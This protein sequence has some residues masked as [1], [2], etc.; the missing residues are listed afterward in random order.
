MNS[1][2]QVISVCR[3]L[4]INFPDAKI[5]ADYANK[6]LSKDSQEKFSLGYFPTNKTLSTL[7]SMLGGNKLSD[8]GLAYDKI[9]QDDV[10]S[11]MVRC[12]VLEHHNLIMPYKD[13]YGET[14]A[15]VGRS[16][17]TDAERIPLKIPK[18]K[19]T[20]FD[21]GSHLFGLFEAKHSIIKNNL[22]YI[23]EGQFDCITAHSK[24]L[25]NVIALG[26]SSMTFEQ[27][28]LITRYTNNLILS[29]DNDAAGKLGS[30]RIM[31]YYS[32]YANIMKANVPSSF[33]DLD[34][35]LSEND[36]ESL[37]YSLK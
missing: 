30:E 19:N 16:I 35:Y 37:I 34:E 4:L 14:I 18:Y 20:S 5:I 15:I 25:M 21:K 9:I 3:D 17:L 6:R 1:F 22:V 12:A 28:C 7:E 33:K 8:M 27:L 26:S 31:K 36:V 10:S 24:G 11:R 2:D 29:L 23:V 32:K 13:V